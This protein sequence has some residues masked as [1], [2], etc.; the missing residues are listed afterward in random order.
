MINPLK[1]LHYTNSEYFQNRGDPMEPALIREE[2]EKGC[3]YEIIR[4]IAFT[5]SDHPFTT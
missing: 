2:L 5:M 3:A 1:S 4:D